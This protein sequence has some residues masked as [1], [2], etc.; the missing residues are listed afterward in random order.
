MGAAGA[1]GGVADQFCLVRVGCGVELGDDLDQD[2]C[3]VVGDATVRGWLCLSLF[4]GHGL[5]AFPR[6]VACFTG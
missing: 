3:G 2:G 6:W 5:C 4:G 1:A